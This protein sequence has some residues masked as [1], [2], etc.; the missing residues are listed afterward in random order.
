MIIFLQ[1]FLV[2]KWQNVGRLLYL[3]CPVFYNKI[4][5]LISLA[6]KIQVQQS[7]MF[8]STEKIA[9]KL[10]FL[11]SLFFEVVH[12]ILFYQRVSR[13]QERFI[14]SSSLFLEVVDSRENWWFIFSS[15]IL[16]FASQDFVR[17][18]NLG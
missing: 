2:K 13:V 1:I 12:C 4:I 8:R 11:T 10:V 3:S 6:K 7:S 17:L 9:R 5:S 15:S 16:N 18:R 14:I